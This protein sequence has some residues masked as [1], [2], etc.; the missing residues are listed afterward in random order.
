MTGHMSKILT[1]L[2]DYPKTKEW[3]K[4]VS[5]VLPSRF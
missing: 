3:N 1:A 5:R 2:M 4:V